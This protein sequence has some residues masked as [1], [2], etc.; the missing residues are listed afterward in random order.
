MALSW[1]MDKLGPMCRTAEDCG[2]VLQVIGG[3]DNKDPGT[4]G[5]SFYFAPQFQRELKT[6]RA[7]YSPIDFEDSAEPNARPAFR[8]ALETLKSFGVTLVETKLPEFPYGSITNT[9]ID[10]EGGSIFQELIESGRVNELADKKQIAGLKASQEVL[11]ID[12]LKAMRIR[13]LIRQEFRKLFT[14]IDVIVSPCR[15]GVAPPITQPLDAPSSTAPLMNR[16]PG[17]RA[18]IPAGNLAG[19]PALSLPCG[20]ADGL[21]VALQLVSRPF[22]ENLILSI[23]MQFQKTTDFHKQ[24]PKV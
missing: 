23:G 18:L 20:F 7:G 3:K 5:R 10:A 6:I 13:T 24:H 11:A 21:P 2:L 15:P 14:E 19:L 17:M 8:Q 22:S 4:A 9:V 16:A 1:T 12:Y